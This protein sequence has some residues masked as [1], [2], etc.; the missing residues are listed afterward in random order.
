MHELSLMTAAME[1]A[2]ALARKNNATRIHVIRMRV[3]ALSGVVPEALEFAF[4]A[5]K[6]GTPAENGKLEIERLPATF[7]CGGCGR[8]LALQQVEFDCP[9][10]GGPLTLAG[11]GR[12]L[13]LADM[14]IS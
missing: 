3:G 13:E 6:P 7:H 9:E 11:G 5:L 10:C 12:E 1:Q 8:D 14:E 2:Q 4:E